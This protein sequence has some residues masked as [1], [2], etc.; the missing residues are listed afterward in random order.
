MLSSRSLRPHPE[1]L[2]Y[3]HSFVQ[4]HSNNR[5]W[6]VEPEAIKFT[7]IG[8][9]AVKVDNVV[10]LS[11]SYPTITTAVPTRTL[12]ADLL[13]MKWEI[14][15]GCK[16]HLLWEGSQ[17]LQSKVEGSVNI[18]LLIITLVE[19]LVLKFVDKFQ[20]EPI[21]VGKNVFTNNGLHGLLV[22]TNS[23]AS[24]LESEKKN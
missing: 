10:R 11:A 13:E 18:S 14:L 5:T 16:E 8:D 2:H 6:V 15:F 20:I 1:I 19:K 3:Q 9:W 7:V 12:Q 17:D 22:L 21:L 4:S 23:I 24:I